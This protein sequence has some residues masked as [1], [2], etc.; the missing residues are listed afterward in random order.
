MRAGHAFRNEATAI[1]RGEREAIRRAEAEAAPDIV[2][3]RANIERID[4]EIAALCSVLKEQRAKDRRRTSDA[5]FRE[6]IAQLRVTK[7]DAVRLFNARCSEVNKSIKST[8]REIHERKLELDRSLNASKSCMWTTSGRASDAV[9]QACAMPR[10]EDGQA[11][12]PP[13]RRWSG[14]GQLGGQI[15]LGRSSNTQFQFDYADPSERVTLPEEQR[16]GQNDDGIRRK[17]S[18]LRLRIGS[19]EQRRPIW[20]T[21]PMVMHRPLPTDAV[22]KYVTVNRRMV[23]RREKWTVQFTVETSLKKQP[24][25]GGT[26]AVDLGWKVVRDGLRPHLGTRLRLALWVGDDGQRG[27]L[28]LDEHEVNGIA[29]ADALRSTR[30]NNFNAA[31]AKLVAWMGDRDL[32]AWFAEAT[33]TLPQWRGIGRLAALALRWRTNRFENDSEAYDALE[34]WR[35]NDRHL[36]DWEV[37]Q[38]ESGLLHRREVARVLGAKLASRYSTV[39][40]AD[41]DFSHDKRRNRTEEDGENAQARSNLHIAAPGET[42]VA[43]INAFDGRDGTVAKYD[44]SHMTTDCHACGHRHERPDT[45]LHKCEGCGQVWDV[46]RNLAMNLLRAHREHLNG[47]AAPATARKRKK[48]NKNVVEGETRWARVRRLRAEKEA[49]IATARKDEPEA[50]E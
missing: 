1:A 21:W 31:R 19:D 26:V 25:N 39:V 34:A 36:W 35:Y 42:R 6:A 11:S 3:L 8:L 41:Q 18:M 17:L 24:A 28:A 49:Q 48:T 46:D 44:A 22:V 30:D 15:Q 20:A 13:F 27:E 12:D 5:E 32:P 14:D 7:R 43:I 47:G 33:A 45:V 29:K 4:G 23:G 16:R 10:Y 9:S 40:F 2:E 37:N 50:A 38:R